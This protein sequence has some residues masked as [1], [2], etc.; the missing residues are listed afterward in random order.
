MNDPVPKS[1]KVVAVQALTAAL[2]DVL[3][4]TNIPTERPDR[5]VVISLIGGSP[6]QFGTS[7]PRFLVECYARGELDAERLALEVEHAWKRLHTHS[8]N[9]GFSDDNVA[10]HASPDPDH[11]RVQFTGAL[12]IRL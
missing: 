9:R 2:P 6:P 8:I 1:G 4:S 7:T 10:E 5:H 12:Q 11:F 3:V